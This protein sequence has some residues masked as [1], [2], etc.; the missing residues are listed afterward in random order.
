[1]GKQV[2]AA[3]ICVLVAFVV[4]IVP[5]SG[6]FTLLMVGGPEMY[7]TGNPPPLYGI[8]LFLAVGAGLLSF[9]A[10]LYLKLL[11]GTIA[12]LGLSALLSTI[13]FLLQFPFVPA[14]SGAAVCLLA[15]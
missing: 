5:A 15:T 8:A 11:Y 12:L 4:W 6:M 10:L 9:A 1:M 13:S 14:I 2:L 7:N 3:I